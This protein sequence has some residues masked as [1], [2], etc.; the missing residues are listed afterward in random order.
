MEPLLHFALPFAFVSLLGLSLHYSFIAGVCGLLPDLDVLFHVH[1]SG[2]HSMPIL[3]VPSILVLL[4]VYK[5]KPE[6]CKHTIVG[7]LSVQSHLI[8]DC[9]AGYTPIL[10]PLWGQSI[11]VNIEGRVL[12]SSDGLI[13][14]ISAS[15]E[16]KLT[17]FNHFETLDA[18][19]ITSEGL[20]IFIILV[21]LPLLKRWNST[22]SQK[23]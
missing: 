21:V 16:T 5:F 11:W 9:F 15:I 1:R 14:Q 7:L 4:V 19:I 8:L 12:I 3:L 13:P 18:K 22:L 6:Y 2:S 17:V 10:Y 20:L 23:H